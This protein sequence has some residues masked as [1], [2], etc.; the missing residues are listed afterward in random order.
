[1][2]SIL[3][4]FQF[5]RLPAAAAAWCLAA[6]PAA[7]VEPD[8][9]ALAAQDLAAIHDTL[10]ADHPGAAPGF[11]PAFAAALA[12]PLP[13]TS[14]VHDVSAYIFSLSAYAN[15]FPDRHLG[16]IANRGHADWAVPVRPETVWPGFVTAWRDGRA[17]V[18]GAAGDAP[19]E[20]AELLACDGRPL[21]DLA[22]VNVFRFWGNA[23]EPADWYGR[24][25]L[26]MVDQGQPGML[27][28]A[29]CRFRLPSGGETELPLVWQ[30][31]SWRS[32]GNALDAAG[33][34]AR[35]AFA[36]RIFAP[37]AAW[38]SLPTFD[39]SAEELPAVEALIAD[40]GRFGPSD[41]LVID[42]RGNGGGSSFLAE[43]ALRALF[44]EATFAWMQRSAMAGQVDRA[45]LRASPGNLE[46]FRAMAVRAEAMGDAATAA[47]AGDLA[48][49]LAAAMAAGEPLAAIEGAGPAPAAGPQPAAVT[50]GQVFVVVD[51]RVFSSALL[52]LDWLA[53]FPGARIVGWPVQ[54]HGLYGEI[55][56]VALPSNWA[57]LVFSTKAFL[58]RA[59]DPVALDAQWPGEIADTPALERWILDLAGR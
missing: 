43:R 47:Y 30:P 52:A 28:P 25:P 15:T 37:S 49:R 45:A 31:F 7:A 14:D 40:L 5:R 34:G 50:P 58:G 55:R 24:L 26:M 18:R 54:P 20:G 12:A 22:A 59:D 51:G 8:W 53:A 10:A 23:G 13:D 11:D 38:V 1:M 44:G 36:A 9:T 39:P 29:A 17:V 4:R 16:V 3:P 2:M 32:Q 46:H 41:I 19:P 33:F 42:L 57:M 56:Q 35:P 27:R 48:D 21:A 6:L